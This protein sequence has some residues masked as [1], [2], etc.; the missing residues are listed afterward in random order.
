MVIGKDAD[1]NAT[2]QGLIKD[3]CDWLFD[4]ERNIT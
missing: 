2:Y 3:I 1:G 4:E